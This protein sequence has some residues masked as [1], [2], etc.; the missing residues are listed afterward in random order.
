[1]NAK[2]D[3]GSESKLDKSD[4]EFHIALAWLTALSISIASVMTA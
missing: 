1:M 4:T 3:N 2:Y